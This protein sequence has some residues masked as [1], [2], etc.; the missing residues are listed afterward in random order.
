[1][2]SLLIQVKTFLVGVPNLFVIETIDS[3]NIATT[4]NAAWERLKKPGR[5]KVMFQINTSGEE[6]KKLLFVTKWKEIHLI[7]TKKVR[8]MFNVIY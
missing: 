8:E 6:S 5:L 2:D 3:E 1:M 4:V 7:H